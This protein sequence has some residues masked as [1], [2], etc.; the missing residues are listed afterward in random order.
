M[1]KL[2]DL[3]G[4]IFGRWIVIGRASGH[5]KH[6]L[7]KCKCVCGTERLIDSY[8]LRTGRTTSCGCSKDGRTKT[9]LYRIWIGMMDRATHFNR[10]RACDY[11]GRGI[12]ICPEWKTWE[13][14]RDWANNN[15]YNDNLSID[16]IDNNKGYY[17]ENCRWV[18]THTQ[19]RNKRNNVVVTINGE[20]HILSDWCKILGLNRMSVKSRIKDGLTPYQALTIPFVKGKRININKIKTESTKH[21]LGTTDMCDEMYI[22]W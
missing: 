13:V 15:G 9:R 10:P 4:Q 17:P 21:L 19:S 18:D 1:G 8:T 5:S 22:N 7:W 12:T 2:I 3:T 16:R 20:T 14:F 11:V 6:T